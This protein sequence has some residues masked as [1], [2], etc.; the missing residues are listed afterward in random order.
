MQ[1]DLIQKSQTITRRLQSELKVLELKKK[2]LFLDK[3]ELNAKILKVE[4]A[5]KRIETQL[6][7]EE[8]LRQFLEN[9]RGE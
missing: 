9:R 8:S 7:N 3:Y 6:A 4:R 1:M 5:I 2:G